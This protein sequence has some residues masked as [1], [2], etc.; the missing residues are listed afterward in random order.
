MVY[1]AKWARNYWVQG[2]AFAVLY[3]LTFY[4]LK[5][6]SPAT[7]NLPVGMRL[8]LFLALPP[9]WWPWLVAGDIGAN[10]YWNITVAVKHHFPALWAAVGTSMPVLA[11]LIPAH[12]NRKFGGPYDFDKPRDAMRFLTTAAGSSLLT[13]LVCILGILAASIGRPTGMTYAD[14]A[15]ASQFTIYLTGALASTVLLPPLVHVVREFFPK[16]KRA[17]TDKDLILIG[18]FAA[19]VLV[20]TL[21]LQSVP[22][23]MLTL[24]RC[25]LYAPLILMTRIMGWRG[26]TIMG[27]VCAIALQAT[28]RVDVEGPFISVQDIATACAV[29][30]FIFGSVI[31]EQRKQVIAAKAQSEQSQSD[32]RQMR[33]LVKRHA[34]RS[35]A[36]FRHSAGIME[37][38]VR[39]AQQAERQMQDTPDRGERALI[40]WEAMKGI[41][42]RMRSL[43]EIFHPE[44]LEQAGLRA[45]ISS[46]PLYQILSACGIAFDDDLRARPGLLSQEVQ[47][48]LYR[49]SYEGACVMLRD[50][51]PERMVVSLRIGR[52]ARGPRYAILRLKGVVSSPEGWRAPTS[53]VT[54]GFSL[55]GMGLVAESFQGRVKYSRDA[56]RMTI[57]LFDGATQAIT[58]TVKALPFSMNQGHPSVTDAAG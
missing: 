37:D 56:H 35:E 46:G 58:E 28:Q 9:R 42:E 13:A 6:A 40:Q 55:D 29:T 20:G 23:G 53:V 39:G 11:G 36:L 19:Y 12:F 49:L 33:G 52:I 34:T 51:T 15:L 24:V 38:L 54:T 2:T 44:L 47:M 3:G 4:H 18:G 14:P 22:I 5:D 31:S 32:V 7:L 8:A 41:R 26:A 43:S 1:L 21:F 17:L 48:S 57:L 50:K 27:L 30:M 45:T 16:G 10:G 25:A